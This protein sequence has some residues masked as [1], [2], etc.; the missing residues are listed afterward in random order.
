MEDQL[1]AI[2]QEM[3]KQ[4][5]FLEQ[6]DDKLKD[7]YDAMPNNGFDQDHFNERIKEVIA[8]IKRLPQ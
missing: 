5:E 7:I 8:A 2:L 3:K 6:I 4:T 1:S